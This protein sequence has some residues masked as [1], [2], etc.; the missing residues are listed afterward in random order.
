MCIIRTYVHVPI[1]VHMNKS[2]SESACL[3]MCMYDVCKW[4]RACLG[5]VVRLGCWGRA[6]AG[7]SSRLTGSGFRAESHAV[8]LAREAFLSV[9]FP[10][11]IEPLRGIGLDLPLKLVSTGLRNKKNKILPGNADVLFIL[12][13]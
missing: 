13:G 7:L 8:L 4:F 5:H 1:D 9:V 11:L 6:P 2:A 3:Y 12:H 10:S